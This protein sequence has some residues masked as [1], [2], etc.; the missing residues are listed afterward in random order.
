LIDKEAS[1]YD[2]LKFRYGSFANNFLHGDGKEKLKIS[3]IWWRDL[4][5]LGGLEVG[6]TPTSVVLLVTE[7]TLVFGE[8]N[9]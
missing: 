9:G 8:I 5:Y 4:W 2:L 3:S 1:W 7:K 6:S